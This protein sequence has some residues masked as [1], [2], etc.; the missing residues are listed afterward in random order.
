M[1][2]EVMLKKIV[3][4]FSFL[5]F[6]NI[7][8]QNY[9]QGNYTVTTTVEE[10]GTE[11]TI[12]MKFDFYFNDGK[13]YLRL[14]TNNSLE[15]YCEGE[16]SINEKKNKVLVLRYSGEGIC[17]N[18]IE[19][20]TIYIKKIKNFYYVKSRRFRSEKWLILKKII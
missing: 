3:I 2:A 6:L 12:K 5:L 17:A 14:D 20:N 16:Y 11:N 13:A 19:I 9:P 8:A 7:C 18:E 4:I 1:N 15:A 10:I